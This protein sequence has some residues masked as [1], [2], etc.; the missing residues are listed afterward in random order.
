MIVQVYLHLFNETEIVRSLAQESQLNA[1]RRDFIPLQC[2]LCK[3]DKVNIQ[4]N[5]YG[6]DL[7]LS[8]KK[9]LVWQGFI[10]KCSFDYHIPYKIDT[11]T[12][13]CCVILSVNGLCVGEMRFITRISEYELKVNTEV[14][15][16]QYNKIFI[17]YAHQDESKV[18]PMARAYQAQGVD[19][20]FDRHY[21]KPGDIFPMK[22]QDYIDTADL[23]ILCWSANAAA[24]DYVELE[25]KR[26]LTRAFPQ[27]M[28]IEDAKLSIYPISIEPRTELP[29]DMKDIYNFEII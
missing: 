15:A 29:A 8:E 21:L 24:S 13:S 7:L 23:F 16:R 20:F 17:S 6:K 1:E 28:P 9:R 27:V 18:E 26:A 14:H 25:R 3:G 2:K 19:Y 5:I 10:T 12:L 11:E 4:L 22:I